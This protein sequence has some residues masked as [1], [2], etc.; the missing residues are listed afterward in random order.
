MIIRRDNSLI[1]ISRVITFMLGLSLTVKVDVTA[2]TK[3]GVDTDHYND[4]TL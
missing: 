3:W 2:R 1:T 4:G